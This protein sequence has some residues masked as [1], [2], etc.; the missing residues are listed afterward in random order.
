MHVDGLVSLLLERQEVALR[1]STLHRATQLL[2]DVTV[3]EDAGAESDLTGSE[4]AVLI[5]DLSKLRL[6]TYISDLESLFVSTDH[7]RQIDL[8]RIQ[9]GLK[10]VSRDL[11][12][13][14]A[15]LSV[16]KCKLYFW[17]FYSI[18]NHH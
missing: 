15:A 9:S 17:V 11:D 1:F 2:N 5:L 18:Q 4:R 3:S 8:Q 6:K 16:T 13:A 7:P 10:Q 14:S 12:V